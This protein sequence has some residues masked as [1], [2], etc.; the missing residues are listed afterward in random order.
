MA[1][2]QIV[3]HARNNTKKCAFGASLAN[4]REYRWFSRISVGS[5]IYKIR[6]LLLILQQSDE[7]C[8]EMVCLL[9]L[10]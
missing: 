8:L 5:S 7:P 6:Q 9:K 4:S 10:K 2:V 1:L 3:L